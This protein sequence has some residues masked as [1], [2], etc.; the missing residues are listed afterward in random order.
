M[1]SSVRLV[2]DRPA[3]QPACDH[4]IWEIMSTLAQHLTSTSWLNDPTLRENSLDRGRTG[5]HTEK[6]SEQWLQ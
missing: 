4:C 1:Q 3:S 6:S 5:W 2:T